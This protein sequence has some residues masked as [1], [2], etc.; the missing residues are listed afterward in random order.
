[1]GKR[2]LREDEAAR[3]H[4]LV[5]AGGKRTQEYLAVDAVSDLHLRRVVQYIHAA[6]GSIGSERLANIT[7]SAASVARTQAAKLP[8]KSVAPLLTIDC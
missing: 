3:Q 2:C 6:E 5:Q 7:G 8:T 4:V 1:M